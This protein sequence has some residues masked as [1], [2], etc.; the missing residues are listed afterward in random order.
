MSPGGFTAEVTGLSPRATETDVHD[1]F[2][3]CGVVEHVEIIRY[4]F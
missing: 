4:C 1:F 2:R 3:N